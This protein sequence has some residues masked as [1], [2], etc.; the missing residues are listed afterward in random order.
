LEFFGAYWSILELI[1][2]YWSLL[3]LIG[4]YWSLLE[5]IGSICAQFVHLCCCKALLWFE[6]LGVSLQS[7]LG[8]AIL[9]QGF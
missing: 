6:V 4:A 3:E 1:G 2:A 9:A 7:D 5:F 8:I